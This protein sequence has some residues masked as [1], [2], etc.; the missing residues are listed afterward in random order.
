MRGPVSRISL[1]IWEK[2]EPLIRVHCAPA[3]GGDVIAWNKA[4]LGARNLNSPLFNNSI[5]SRVGI[6]HLGD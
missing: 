3:L 1:E 6:P 2:G 5:G 4:A